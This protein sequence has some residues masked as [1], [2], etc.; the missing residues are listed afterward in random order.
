MERIF[1]KWLYFNP[2]HEKAPDFVVW[3]LSIKAEQ[4]K[5]LAEQVNTYANEKWY[6]RFQITQ[7]RDGKYSV[8]VDT[9]KPEKKKEEITLEDIPF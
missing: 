9:Y 4:L 6:A 8:T 3:S 1:W 2:K 7:N 5:E